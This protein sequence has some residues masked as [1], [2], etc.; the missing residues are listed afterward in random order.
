MPF[1]I[2]YSGQTG[3]ENTLSTWQTWTRLDPDFRGR[4]LRMFAASGGTV[5]FGGGWRSPEEQAAGYARNPQGFAPAGKSWHEVGMAAD[6]VGD[7]DWIVAN[8][9]RFGLRSFHDVNNEPWHVQPVEIPGARPAG[10]PAPSLGGGGGSV[11]DAGAGSITANAGATAGPAPTQ[12]VQL[13][14][15]AKIYV[16]DGTMDVYA[17]FDMGAVKIAYKVD[18]GQGAVDWINK[19]RTVVSQANW[20]T[21]GVVNAGSTGELGTV[22]QTFGSFSAFWDSI[23]GQVMGYNNPARH[24]PEVLKIIAEFAARPDMSS[25]ELQNKLQATQWFQNRTQSELEW[26]SVSDAER[27]KRREETAAKMIATW[28]QFGGIQ[29][30]MS[31]PWIQNYLEQVASGRL[32]FGAWTELVKK[33]AADMPESPYARDLREEEEAQRQRPIDIENTKLRIRQTLQRWGIEWTETEIQRWGTEIMEKRS[34]DDDL[35]GVIKQQAA[36]LYPWKDPELETLQAAQP[37]LSTYERVMES[38]GSL[39][40]PQIQA[41][42]TAGAPAWEFEQQLKLSPKWLETRNAQEAMFTGAANIGRRLGFE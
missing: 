3:D 34:S 38:T 10:A 35:M 36:V 6:L 29:M 1:P 17:V 2:G 30:D 27:N 21:L 13:P 12:T 39:T 40:E 9:A 23:L 20:D 18:T 15:D 33:A 25:Q 37:W 14:S 5:G 7:M 28:Q 19:P 22:S 24:D 8:A 42:L 16:I 11:P 26:N 32:G 41:A 4:L 31:H